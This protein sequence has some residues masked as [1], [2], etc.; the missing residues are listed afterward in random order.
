MA[1]KTKFQFTNR[2]IAALPAHD[3]NSSAK[4]A[5]YSDLAVVGLKVMV[6]V[7]GVKRFAFRYQTLSGR[8]RYATLGTVGALDVAQARKLALEMRAIVERG[9]DPLEDRDRIK[10]MPTFSEFVRQEYLQ[11]AYQTK[12][13]AINDESKFRLHLEPKLGHLRLCD[14]TPRD[15]QMHHASIKESHSPGTANRHL[16]L[17]S[18]TFRKALEWGRADRNPVAGIKAFKENN[19]KQRF[20]SPEEIG[21]LFVAMESEK[22][23]VAVAALKLLLLTGTRRQE[24]LSA[25]WEHINLDQGQWWLP[26]T[27]NGRGRYVTL[28][29]EVK[30]LL[31][32]LPSRESGGWVFPSRIEGKAFHNPRKAL[33]RLLKAAGIEHLRI[34]DLRHSFAS[35]AVNSGATLYEV[36]DL[37]GHSTSQMTQRYAHLAD[38]GRVRVVGRV[39]EMVR[40]AVVNS[41]NAVH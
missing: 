14:I 16:A 30:A 8:K 36:Q 9:G 13:S 26:Q 40:T 24:A 28:S 18:A 10:T 27:K 1:A 12:R 6:G 35:L 23:Q 33:D 2:N 34:H 37:L 32:A 11:Y 22:N 21:R 17:L 29:D 19:Q 41:S 39:A 4:A 38:S 3:P 20:L 31:M 5:E 7:N 25:R 15:I